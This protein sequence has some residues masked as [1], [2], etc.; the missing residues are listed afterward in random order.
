MVSG[1]AT[2]TVDGTVVAE[3]DQWEEVEGN[4]YFPP[5]AVKAE[6]LTETDLHTTCSWKGEAS[7]YTIA[8]NGKNV[9]VLLLSVWPGLFPA[10]LIPLF[11][12]LVCSFEEL[13]ALPEMARVVSLKRGCAVN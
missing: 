7:Y 6:L 9:C 2:A 1:H 5:A 13:R 11:P 10:S 3:T 4:V 12:P 8:V